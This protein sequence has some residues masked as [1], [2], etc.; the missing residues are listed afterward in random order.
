MSVYFS[1]LR[2][3]RLFRRQAEPRTY[4][5]CRDQ[6]H[7]C[8]PAACATFVNGRSYTNFPD[9][10]NE[11]KTHK[12]KVN[13][14]RKL[15]ACS[16]RKW[17]RQLVT[18]LMT[19]QQTSRPTYGCILGQRHPDGILRHKSCRFLPLDFVALN[20]RRLNVAP[21]L[22]S[23]DKCTFFA[24]SSIS[25]SQRSRFSDWNL[26]ENWENE[27]TRNSIANCAPNSARTATTFIMHV[28][29]KYWSE[30]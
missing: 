8:Q 27:K 7:A 4:V 17:Q 15:S 25:T 2:C 19:R 23:W 10:H 9:P 24:R 13:K 3:G 14:S 1:S 6:V 21:S 5:D 20:F 18:Q 30:I 28:S 11:P 29:R 22:D 12:R 16:E 26:K